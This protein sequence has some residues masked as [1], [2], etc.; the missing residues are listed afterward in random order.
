MR[1]GCQARCCILILV[2]LSTLIGSRAAAQGTSTPEER[3][4][5]VEVTRKLENAPL[6]DIVTKQ[7]EA[8]LKQVSDAHD[9]HVPLCPAL[10][11][12][13][14]G[15]KY[16][17]SHA[18]TRQYMLASTAFLIENAGK[19]SDLDAMNLAAVESV[20]LKKQSHPGCP[21]PARCPADGICDPF[22]IRFRVYQC[23]PTTFVP[24]VALHVVEFTFSGGFD[25]FRAHHLSLQAQD[26]SRTLACVRLWKIYFSLS[27]RMQ[28]L[29]QFCVLD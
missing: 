6:D 10:L 12:E 21:G 15:M 23:F 29:N 8:A 4:Q 22:A 9:I 17:Y 19:A 11:S 1:N 18:I 3:M 7:G 14:N 5:W 25:S 24:S 20:L 27:Q 2:C 26:L 16:T 13:F 28:A